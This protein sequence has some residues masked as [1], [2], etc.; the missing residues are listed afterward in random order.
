MIKGA[1]VVGGSSELISEVSTIT[2][3]V[4]ASW[5][6]SANVS[7]RSLS[8]KKVRRIAD[9]IRKGLWRLTHQGVAFYEDD[10]LA[11]GQH[12]LAAIVM[13]GVP[14][15]VMVTYG[16]PVEVHDSI[17]KG[18]ART[19]KDNMDFIGVK[20]TRNQL[21]AYRCLYA[22][23]DRQL[24]NA[25]IWS[26]QSL[27][28]ETSE[29]AAFQVKYQGAIDFAVSVRLQP[30]I[31]LS[32]V[33]A[34]VAAASLTEN[35]VRLEEFMQILASGVASVQEDSAAIRLREY[36]FT[37]T[38]EKGYPGRFDTYVRVCTAITAFLEHRGLTKLYARRDACFKLPTAS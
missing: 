31:A 22:E 8:D 20:L 13:A 36:L 30:K 19:L 17:D 1:I 6:A 24:N 38:L 9:S 35:R 29:F 18:L 23:Y 34:A 14:V 16:L 2:P 12:R 7:N 37:N 32:Q 26:A 27:Y 15:K 28:V 10:R 3:E 33:Y 21:A 25:E 11:D 5:L 4:A